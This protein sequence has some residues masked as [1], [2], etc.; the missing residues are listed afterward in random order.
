MKQDLMQEK[1]PDAELAISRWSELKTT[2]AH[3]EQDWEDIARLIRPQRANFSVTMQRNKASTKI[4][5]SA[6]VMANTNLA[7]GL[8]GTLTNPANRWM[9]FSVPQGTVDDSSA[10]KR[11]LD[12]VT[13]RVLASFQ[14]SMSPFYSAAI[15]LFTDLTAFGNAAQYDEVN[16]GEQRIMDVTL[17]LAEVCFEIDAYGRVSEVVRKFELMP[18]AAV[19]MFGADRVPPKVLEQAQQHKRELGTYYH[20]VRRNVNLRKGRIG[21]EGKRFSSVYAAEMG[22]TLL[23]RSGYDEMPFHAPRWEVESGQVYGTGPAHVALASARMNNLMSDA[24]LRAGQR[25][26]DPTILAPDRDGFPLNGRI[27]PGQVVYGGTDQRGQPLLRPIDTTS[28]T[29]LTVELQAQVQEEIRDAFQWTLMNMAGR[30]GMTATEVVQI[31]EEKMRLMAPF[32]GRVQEEFLHP[33]A[34]RRFNLL[35]RNGQLPPPPPEAEGVP[36]EV[37]YTSQA[38]RAQKSAEGASVMRLLADLGPLAQVNPAYM[39]RVNP[40]ETMEILQEAYGAPAKVLR[41]RDEMAALQAERAE[42][43]QMAEAMQMMQGG[44]SAAKDAAAAAGA[45][46]P[47]GMAESGAE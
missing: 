47:D 36:L 28:Q 24:V 29:G 43:Q 46:L 34:M 20:H 3:H 38:A 16:Q 9:G 17:S 5:S 2:R 7:S 37:T 26:A 1:H 39:D 10:V 14:P 35:W 8:Y 18:E 4:L 23:R 6:P 31:Q 32:T 25:A 30:T 19:G 11:W 21:P 33:K 15:Q 42:Q 13:T 40:D 12:V 44:A 22:A 41:S 27:A 45:M